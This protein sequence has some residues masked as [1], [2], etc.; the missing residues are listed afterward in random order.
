MSYFQ[1]EANRSVV[2]KLREA[3]VRLEDEERVM[4]TEQPFVGMRFVVTGRLERFS[5]SQVQDLIKQYGGA[6]SGSVSKNTKL[7]RRGRGR[8]LEAGGRAAA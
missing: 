1:N 5:R 4:P 7:P 3:R 8:R 6:V 2:E